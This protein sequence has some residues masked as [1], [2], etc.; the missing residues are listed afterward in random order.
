MHVKFSYCD[1]IAYHCAMGMKDAEGREAGLIANVGPVQ[2][3]LN[4]Q[5]Q[6]CSTKKTI[7]VV[8]VYGKRYSV[9]IEEL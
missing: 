9:T 5:G 4:E 8:D 2:F 1:Y 3:D 6:F 7:E